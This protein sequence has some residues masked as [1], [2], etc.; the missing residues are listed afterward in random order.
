MIG[1]LSNTAALFM[2]PGCSRAFRFPA[3][4]LSSFPMTYRFHLS[5]GKEPAEDHSCPSAT[6]EDESHHMRNRLAQQGAGVQP[7]PAAGRGGADPPAG[8]RGRR[9]GR[10]GKAGAGR[11]RRGA[12]R[13]PEQPASSSL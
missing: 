3:V 8:V 10:Q 4:I 11:G 5:S 12:G 2:V 6:R 1:L 13:H 9:H 7:G